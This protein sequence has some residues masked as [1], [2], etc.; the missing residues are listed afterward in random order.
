MSNSPKIIVITGAESTGKSVLTKALANHFEVPFIP[1]IARGYVEK[2][3][4]KYNYRDVEQ[5]AH[6]Q[7]G[8]LNRL[9]CAG[10]PLLFMD[11]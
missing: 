1:E 8:L 4:R 9:S 6:E 5:I 2:L 3:N 10:Y 7:V 11:T